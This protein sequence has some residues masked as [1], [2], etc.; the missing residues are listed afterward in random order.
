[1]R[2]VLRRP[3]A[4][5]DHGTNGSE[6]GAPSSASRAGEA[7]AFGLEGFVAGGRHVVGE[8]DQPERGVHGVE[9]DFPGIGHVG[10]VLAEIGGIGVADA[11][12]VACGVAEEGEHAAHLGGAAGERQGAGVN[13]SVP[14][15]DPVC[16]RGA[17]RAC[18]V[19]L[20]RRRDGR[21]EAEVP[22]RKG[23]A[24]LE[25]RV[26]RAPRPEV[27]EHAV[28]ARRGKF[29]VRRGIED[30]PE[31]VDGTIP[32]LLHVEAELLRV[33]GAAREGAGID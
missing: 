23:V 13:E 18:A 22:V 28:H 31:E 21:H 29:L 20:H 8:E 2:R 1:M 12:A 16:R 30:P 10:V 11:T 14:A 7:H 6:S 25:A 24:R 32:P 26:G 5:A 33:V 9:I 17:E 3:G 4:S 19:H 27:L 15:P